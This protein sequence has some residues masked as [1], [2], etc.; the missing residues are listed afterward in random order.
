MQFIKFL[1]ADPFYEAK[2]SEVA[3]SVEHIARIEPIYYETNARGE[4]FRTYVEVPGKEELLAG[5][6]RDFLVVD[7]SGREYDS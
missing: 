7:C 6:M 1:Q 4:R 5:K 3:V 2:H